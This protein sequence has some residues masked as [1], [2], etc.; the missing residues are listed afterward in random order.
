MILCSNTGWEKPKKSRCSSPND[1][2]IRDQ[3][4]I[5]IF[6]TFYSLITAYIDDI[7]KSRQCRR[8]KWQS[9]PPDAEAYR[10]PNAPSPKPSKLLIY[11][12][13]KL[14]EVDQMSCTCQT[15][16]YLIVGRIVLPEN[17]YIL[18]DICESQWIAIVPAL[19]SA[20]A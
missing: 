15:A 13:R 5:L 11:H 8:G 3:I 10:I 4:N 9:K 18:F 1:Y 7:Q 12:A 14:L 19:S 16:G 20:G 17:E 2:I 6:A